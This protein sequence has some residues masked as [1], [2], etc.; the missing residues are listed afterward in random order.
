MKVVLVGEESAGLGAL[1][2]LLD[3]GVPPVAVLTTP[4][5][6]ERRGFS[7]WSE[8]H[9]LGVPALPAHA[10]R[11]PV[12]DHLHQAGIDLL[13]NVHSLHVIRAPWLTLPRL[14]AFNLHPGLLPEYAGLDSASWALYEGAGTHGVTLHH[15]EPGIDTGPIAWQRRFPIGA[16][17][18]ALRLNQRSIREGLGLLSLL[19]EAAGRGGT[20]I[21]RVPQDLSRRRYLGRTPPEGG[22][23][24]IEGPVARCIGL[25]R[26]CDFRPFPSPWGTP[27]LL[28]GDRRVE[29]VQASP[30]THPAGCAAGTLGPRHDDGIDLACGDGFLRVHLVRW[31]GTVMAA[32]EVLREGELLRRGPG[33]DAGG[34]KR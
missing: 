9:R 5:A 24:P 13:L 8:A 12:P 29:I 31:N 32:Q 16:A 17:D 23:L 30:G 25:V 18:T 3:R 26:A 6:A 10:V 19:L 28:R 4:P 21:P 11:E 14:G 20:A 1:R 2:L 7:L 34:T 22:W 27:G 15:M 33:D